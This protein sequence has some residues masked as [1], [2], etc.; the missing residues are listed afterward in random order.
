MDKIK[1]FLHDNTDIFAA[2]LIAFA[3][4]SVVAVNLGDW[5]KLEA[6]IVMAE[7]K[8]VEPKSDINEKEDVPTP[9]VEE[10]ADM[11]ETPAVE[12]PVVT[13]TPVATPPT[14]I[15]EIKRIVI[16][17]GT[18]GSGIAR[19]LQQKGLFANTSDF[20]K[21]AEELKLSPKLKSGTFEIPSN[22]S[23]EDMVKII[24]GQK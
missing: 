18:T 4:F 8:N 12:T 16:P 17:S 24:A 10:E 2:L 6:G 9:E 21:V 1:D 5:F 19:I 15:V 23:I 7:E 3:M 11:P 14:V 20:V 22:A 13:P